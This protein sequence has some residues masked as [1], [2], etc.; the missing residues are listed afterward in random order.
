M[1][2]GIGS[3]STF[4]VRGRFF[5]VK[6]THEVILDREHRIKPSLQDYVRYECRNDFPGRVEVLPLTE[7]EVLSEPAPLPTAAPTP[8]TVAHKA[9]E[10]SPL[11]LEVH[12]EPQIELTSEA[13][14]NPDLYQAHVAGQ[15][16]H[17]QVDRARCANG[18]GQVGSEQS[19]IDSIHFQRH[20][21]KPDHAR[22]QPTTVT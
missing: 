3:G 12:S 9:D 1:L 6:V 19:V 16:P 11:A 5:V 20:L 7:Q 13:E 18:D 21:A 4:T 15:E 14:A 8:E 17:N 22:A 2:W 10:S